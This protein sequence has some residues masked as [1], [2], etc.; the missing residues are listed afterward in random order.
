MASVLVVDKSRE[1]RDLLYD[2]FQSAGHRS[3]V[4]SDGLEAL[5]IFG[6]ERPELVLTDLAIPMVDGLDLLRRF[7]EQEPDTAIIVMS[8]DWGATLTTRP[9]RLLG[10][11]PSRIRECYKRGAFKVLTKPVHVDEVLIYAERALEW[12]RLHIE[13]RSTAS[14]FAPS[15]LA[16]AQEQ[17][18]HTE[19]SSPSSR[20]PGSP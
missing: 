16:R 15:R 12:R 10:R 18:G 6:R 19:G 9:E 17:G 5:E 8:G 7:R 2:I 14:P 4:A 11:E 20:G 13:R 1:V 3:L